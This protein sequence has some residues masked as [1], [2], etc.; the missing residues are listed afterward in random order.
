MRPRRLRRLIALAGF[1]AIIAGG[2]LG[3][4][5]ARADETDQ[6]ASLNA[7]RI[8][9]TLDQYPTVAGVTGILQAVMNVGF[10]PHDAGL[11]VAKAVVNSCPEHLPE[12]QRFVAAYS[13]AKTVIA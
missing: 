12:L 1:G 3:T 9:R 7:G 13:P 5:V 10:T 11:V 2:A 8:C 6:Y 4:G